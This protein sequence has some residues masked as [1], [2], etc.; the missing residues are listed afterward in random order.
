[1]KTSTESITE[2]RPYL[3]H[4]FLSP[5][6]VIYA[7]ISF[8]ISG[9]CIADSLWHFIIFLV[10]GILCIWLAKILYDTSK[11]KIIL[12]DNGLRIIESPHLEHHYIPWT[13]ITHAYDFINF[14]GHSFLVLSPTELSKVEIKKFG[15]KGANS[16][17]ISIDNVVVIPIP[18]LKESANIKEL[19]NQKITS[20]G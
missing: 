11:T 14:K 13:T 16:S 12:E 9:V 6:P 1:M 5:L 4:I 7:L 2:Y 3:T 8:V 15:S 19:I 17:K 20:V 18:P 10:L